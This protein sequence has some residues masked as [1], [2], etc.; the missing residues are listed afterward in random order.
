VIRPPKSVLWSAALAAL[1]AVGCGRGESPDLVNGKRLF[2]ERCGSCHVLDRAGTAG[3]I[4][5]ALDEAFVAARRAGLGQQTIRGVVR[6]QIAN[7]R[8][9]SEM[10]ADLVE[11]DDARDVAAYVAEVAGVPGEDTGRLAQVGPGGARSGEQVFTAAGCNS[12]HTLADAGSSSDIGPNLDQLADAAGGRRR[13]VSAEEY[14]RESIL[15]PNAFVVQGFR[16]GVMPSDYGE[17]LS[18]E[19][20]DALVDYLLR[21]SGG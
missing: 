8:R 14:V 18:D 6:Q 9:N 13:G 10:P 11:G 16:G 3:K 2:I 19:Q 7:P 1:L 15:E 5:P 4:G 20:I 17:R 12:C 21:V